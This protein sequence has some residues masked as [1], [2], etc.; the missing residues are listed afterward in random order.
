[1][2]VANRCESDHFPIVLLLNDYS[3]ESY[4]LNEDGP[5]VSME[6]RLNFK[7]SSQSLEAFTGYL[8]TNVTHELAKFQEA[9]TRNVD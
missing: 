1:M 6:S 2:F 4:E 8:Q 5:S 3:R 9:L 7:V